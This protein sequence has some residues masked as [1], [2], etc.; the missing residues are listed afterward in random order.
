MLIFINGG[1]EITVES[2]II[3]GFGSTLVIV[4]A[5]LVDG[6]SDKREQSRFIFF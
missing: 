6:P 4:N 3:I 5:C 1:K 2:N